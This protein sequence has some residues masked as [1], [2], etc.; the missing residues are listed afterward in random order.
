MD[1]HIQDVF[2]Q[3]YSDFILGIHLL[4]ISRLQIQYLFKGLIIVQNYFAISIAF[5][6]CLQTET[7]LNTLLLFVAN[8]VRTKRT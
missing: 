2:V 8:S 7:K 1:I 5:I 4:K 3:Q 6:H